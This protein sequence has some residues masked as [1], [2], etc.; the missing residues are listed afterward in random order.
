MDQAAAA[1]IIGPDEYR[2]LKEAERLTA[3]VIRVDDFAPEEL[4]RGEQTWTTQP[5]RSIS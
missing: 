5:A 4:S 2:L 3:E 1:G